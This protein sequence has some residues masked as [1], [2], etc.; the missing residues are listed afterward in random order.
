MTHWQ[1][2]VLWADREYYPY[3]EGDEE[4]IKSLRQYK[5]EGII[6]DYFICDSDGNASWDTGPKPDQIDWTGFPE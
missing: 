4:F 5:D 2:I 3:R 6:S 1:Q